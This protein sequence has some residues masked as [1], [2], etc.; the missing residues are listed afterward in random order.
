MARTLVPKGWSRVLV[1]ML[2]VGVGVFLALLAD[3]ALDDRQSRQS[4]ARYLTNLLPEMRAAREEL[5]GDDDRRKGRLAQLD[6]LQTQFDE[7]TAADSVSRSSNA[8]STLASLSEGRS[9]TWVGPPRAR[10]SAETTGSERAP[11]T[12]SASSSAWL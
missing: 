7:R 12:H 3:A 4:E 6:S 9:A 8:R 11:A 2:V 1:E 10:S 5:R